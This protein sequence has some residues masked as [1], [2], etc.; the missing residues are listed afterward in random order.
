[1]GGVGFGMINEDDNKPW[2]PYYVQKMIGN[3]LSV[4]DFIVESSSSSNDVR[5]L[6]WLHNGELKILLICKVD[7]AR[8]VYFNGISGK[9]SIVKIDNNIPWEN[10]A[11]QAGTIEVNDPL[12]LE[13]YT[14]ALL[15]V[16]L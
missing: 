11:L 4:G 9:L 14:V 8:M 5:V 7:Q 3:N 6:S 13:R 1:S 15:S 10:P 16:T 12:V 2:Y